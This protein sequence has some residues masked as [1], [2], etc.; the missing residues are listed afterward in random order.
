MEKIKN[1]R[2]VKQRK[3]KKRSNASRNK[4]QQKLW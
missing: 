1:G 3:I 2:G 4:N